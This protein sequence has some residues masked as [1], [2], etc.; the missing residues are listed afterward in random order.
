MARSLHRWFTVTSFHKRNSA[1]YLSGVEPASPRIMFC[2]DLS[3]FAGNITSKSCSDE[4]EKGMNMKGRRNQKRRERRR[5]NDNA[6][7]QASAR[8]GQE[9]TFHEQKRGWMR[10]WGIRAT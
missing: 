7:E 6:R 8:V 2:L 10:Q 4:M 5:R 9:D 3:S 1:V